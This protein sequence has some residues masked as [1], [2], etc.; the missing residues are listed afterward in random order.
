M[1]KKVAFMGLALLLACLFVA[2][3][4]SAQN[5]KTDY[6]KSYNFG[7]LRRF[8]WKTNHLIT[9]R[10]PEDNRILDQK[11]MRVVTQ[12]LASKG[13][14]EDAA[15]PDFYLFYHAGPGDEGLMTGV[16]A[17][18]GLESIRPAEMNPAGSPMWT[19]GAGTNVGFAPNVWYSVQGKFLFYAVD[20]KSQTVIWE[21]TATKK[22][23]DPRKAR[24]NEDKEIRQVVD[25]SFKG[26][27]PKGK[28]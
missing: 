3:T 16:A 22:W 24:K 12:D 2:H 9:N 5:I 21:S 6:V 19:A 27:P 17:P 28:K 7:S 15:N 23:H 26:F 10:N 13:I 14:V 20:T 8:A 11:I 25:K 1:V 4:S 18:A